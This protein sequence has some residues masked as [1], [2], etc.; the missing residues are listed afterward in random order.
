MRK[1]FVGLM[2]LAVLLPVGASAQG[3][4]KRVVHF[5]NTE[6][7]A[8][9]MGFLAMELPTGWFHDSTEKDPFYVIKKGESYK[10]AKV[11]MYVNAEPLGSPFDEAVKDDVSAFRQRCEKLSVEDLKR[12]I[13]LEKACPV[14]SQMFTCSK[15]DGSYVDLD[16]KIAISGLL[17]NVVLSAPTREELEKYKADYNFLLQHLASGQ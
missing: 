9:T 1:R 7:Y 6:F 17:V 10:S 4:G 12:P 5:D 2:I 15:K 8:S 16:T 14:I 11:L 13:I 3:C